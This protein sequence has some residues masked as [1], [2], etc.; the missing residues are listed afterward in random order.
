[1]NSKIVYDKEVDVMSIELRRAK[2]VD[3]DVNG[4]VVIDYDKNGKIVRINFYNFNLD[5]FKNN[6]Y[7]MEEFSKE[8]QSKVEI[9]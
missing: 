5:S 4:N 1:M 8:R 2:S 9:R 3:S 6:R 7:A